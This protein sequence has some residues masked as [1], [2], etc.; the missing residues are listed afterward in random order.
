MTILDS[1]SILPEFIKLRWNEPY[2]SAGL[3]RKTFK[4]LPR[5]VYNG[6]VVKPGPG[7]NQLQVV[8]DD[9]RGWAST[10]GYAAGAFDMASGWSIAVHESVQGYNAT[11]AIQ[12]AANRNFIF[13]IAAYAG[14]TIYPALD[15]QMFPSV[16]VGWV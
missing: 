2:V 7:T 4:S 16:V 10:S 5:G 8:H 11:I 12:A 3:N 13:D 1:K 9:P 14:S 6:F 15:L